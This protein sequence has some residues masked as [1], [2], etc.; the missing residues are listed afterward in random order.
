MKK[1]EKYYKRFY[2]E[3]SRYK[4]GIHLLNSGISEEKISKFEDTYNIN[5]PYYYREWLKI[6]NGGELFSAMKGTILAGIADSTLHFG[7]LNVADN[8][9][10][11]KRLPGMPNYMMFL[12]WTNGGDLIGYDLNHTDQMDGKIIYW[13]SEKK[14]VTSEWADFAEWL[15]DEMAY[16]KEI[17][18]Y[19]GKKRE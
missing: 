18:D 7:K 15:E 3:L 9:N 8:F 11:A 1:V 4:A 16:W 13:D 10:V 14:E 5:L 17:I 2:K 6:N 12:A 19:D